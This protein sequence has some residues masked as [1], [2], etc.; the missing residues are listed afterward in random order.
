PIVIR[1]PRNNY[2]LYNL[3]DKK[4]VE[5]WKPNYPI[6]CF[7][8]QLE[9]NIFKKYKLFYNTELEEFPI[10][11]KLKLIKTVATK[12]PINNNKDVLVIGSI[13][14]FEFE[15]LSKEKKEILEFALDCGFGE[16][17]SY[18]FGF[19]NIEK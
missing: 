7:L 16:K 5:Y 11:E 10:F 6:S 13:W 3:K 12:L 17:N 19:V 14:E 15:N 8:K 1:I 18:G 2:F 9:E 4:R